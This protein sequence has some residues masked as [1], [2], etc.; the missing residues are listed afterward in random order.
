MADYDVIVIGAGHNGLVTAGYLAKAGR[1]VLVL[2]RRDC[3]GGA[4]VTEEVFPGFRFST[5]ADGSGYLCEEVRRDLKPDVEIFN[6]DPVVFAP[7]PDGSRLAIWRD[8]AK[9]AA[10]IEP[11]SR[12]DAERYPQFIAFVEKI[13]AVVGGLARV[14]PPDLP[15]VG[16]RDLLSLRPMAGPLRSLGRKHLNDLLRVLPMPV[17]DL[18]DEWFESREISVERYALRSGRVSI[19]R[20]SPRPTLQAES[21]R[22]NSAG[23][24]EVEGVLELA[25]KSS[26]ARKASSAI[27]TRRSAS[28]SC[29]RTVR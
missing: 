9:T 24:P 21:L 15:D 22:S 2:E 1:R 11:F 18:L 26:P 8:P 10:E 23:L 28:S 19:G 16:L 17:A 3:V 20:S 14:A 4:A 12:A 7:Q 6:A 29:S 13:A 5:C 25:T 27:S